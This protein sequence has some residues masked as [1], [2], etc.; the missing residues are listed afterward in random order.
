[1]KRLL[2]PLSLTFLCASCGLSDLEKK[3]Y[4]IEQKLIDDSVEIYRKEADKLKDQAYEFIGKARGYK[5]LSANQSNEAYKNW[6]KPPFEEFE[7][8]NMW[9][10]Y[11]ACTEALKTSPPNKIIEKHIALHKRAMA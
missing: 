7:D 4:A 9:S 2:L 1:M 11:N 5:L 10:L 6:D 8:N 3:Y